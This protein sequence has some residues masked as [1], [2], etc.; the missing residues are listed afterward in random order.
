[1]NSKIR[2]EA[3]GLLSGNIARLFSVSFVSFILRYTTLLILLFVLYRLYRS[4]TFQ[5]L[6]NIYGKADVIFPS[7]VLGTIIFLLIL[8]F[9]S[10][11]KLGET[12]V[13]FTLANG[14]SGKIHLLF[15]FIKPRKALKA[16]S[17]YLQLNFR[18]LAW[19]LF[20]IIPCLLCGTAYYYLLK[21]YSISPYTLLTV[22]VCFSL[23]IA[24]SFVMIRVSSLRLGAAP[25]Y[26]FLNKNQKIKKAI[27]KSIIYTDGY[28]SEGVVLEYSLSGWVLSCIFIVPLVYVVPFIKL[29]RAVYISSVVTEKSVSKAKYPICFL[30]QHIN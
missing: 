16:F 29:T 12:A 21:S 4:G 7:A 13:Y 8:I 28:L 17:L 25:Y 18:K 11:I 26:I 3:K 20:F 2:L 14:G 1:M 15:K 30:R 10:C 5:E 23:L 19:A 27:N 24:L 6:I 9:D 22:S